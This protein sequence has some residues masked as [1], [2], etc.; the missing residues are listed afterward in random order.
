MRE[1][2]KW[3]WLNVT[4]RP[5]FKRVTSSLTQAWND[6]LTNRATSFL[7]NWFLLVIVYQL[8]FLYILVIKNDWD[9][10]FT[11]KTLLQGI[12]CIISLTFFY[13]HNDWITSKNYVNIISALLTEAVISLHQLAMIPCVSL[14]FYSS[15]VEFLLIIY[16]HKQYLPSLCMPV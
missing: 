1:F 16:K 8:I 2:I 4:G 14:F 10:C 13:L 12:T 6:A 7:N 11:E 15:S 9:F 3:Y 5:W